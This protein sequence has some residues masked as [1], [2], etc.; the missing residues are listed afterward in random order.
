MAKVSAVAP[1]NFEA[2]MAELDLLVE[3]GVKVSNT[4]YTSKDEIKLSTVL[5]SALSLEVKDVK[6]G[7]EN[8]RGYVKV[9]TTQELQNV[10]LATYYTIQ[11]AATTKAE[12]TENGFII[13]GDF[14][15]T[16][17]YVLTLTNQIKGTLG[18]RLQEPVRSEERR[19]GKEC[20]QP[21]RSRWSPDH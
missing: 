8:N 1:K 10:D 14:N 18:A 11:P 15:E 3:K 17:T 4:A 6:T 5:P 19:V 13:R 2:A 9:V 7:F 21:C 20:V 16:D 12:L